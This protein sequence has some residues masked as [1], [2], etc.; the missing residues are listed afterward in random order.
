MK[1]NQ[2]VEELQTTKEQKDIAERLLQD[3]IQQLN[4]KEQTLG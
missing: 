1:L 2:T 3:K 4:K